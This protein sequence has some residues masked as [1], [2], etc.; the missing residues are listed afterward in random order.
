MAGIS[1]ESWIKGLLEHNVFIVQTGGTAPLDKYQRGVSPSYLEI[2]KRSR[3]VSSFCNG[4]LEVNLI[5][6]YFNVENIYQN[7]LPVSFGIR[8][9]NSIWAKNIMGLK[10]F[11]IFH[12][13]MKRAESPNQ[14]GSSET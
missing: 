11:G 5:Q 10:M 8:I 13:S 12:V 3:K 1:R 6:G 14:L 7:I 2:R 4:L 9:R